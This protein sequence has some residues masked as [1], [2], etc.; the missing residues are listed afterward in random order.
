MNYYVLTSASNL[1]NILSSESISPASLYGKRHYGFTSIETPDDGTPIDLIR[2]HKVFP[3]RPHSDE[4]VDFMVLEIDSSLV[5]AN[6]GEDGW[7]G[8]SKTIRIMPTKCK[9]I[10]YEKEDLSVAFNAT[11]MSVEAK[12]ADRYR[13]RAKVKTSPEKK[14]P[15]LF[16]ESNES[17]SEIPAVTAPTENPQIESIERYELIDRIKGA[18]FGY[19]LGDDLSLMKDVQGDY[20]KYMATVDDLINGITQQ[21]IA[22]LN[23]KKKVLE[24]LLY[25]LALK[26]ELAELERQ[27]DST[28]DLDRRLAGIGNSATVKL[29]DNLRTDAF[30]L[31]VYRS[32]LEERIRV[33]AGAKTRSFGRPKVPEEDRG[34]VLELPEKDG[35]IATDLVNRMIFDDVLSSTKRA[36]GYPFGL[37]CGKTLR[38]ILGESWDGS[39]ERTFING[40]LP[41]LNA[42]KKFDP[43]ENPG[44]EDEKSFTVLKTLAYLCERPDNKEL[45]AFY[46]YLLIK[47]QVADFALPFALWGASFGFSSI[48]KTL[49][50]T[51]STKTETAARKLFE[52][53]LEALDR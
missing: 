49:C 24:R 8:T 50:D 45:D 15:S 14:E 33:A 17:A 42:G 4:G 32:D 13:S 28:F 25:K 53:A 48:P 47:C 37:Q 3:A 27:D 7:L 34:I 9:F 6:A 36:L 43:E 40:L 30:R 41:H 11:R 5:E 12:F 20:V 1:G 31:N 29:P 39:G 19:C 21:P 38:E 44:I 35:E 10:F 52:K 16:G 26:R 46:R 2:L 18:I 22:V 23:S 51:M